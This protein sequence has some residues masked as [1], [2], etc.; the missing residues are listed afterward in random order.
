MP[1]QPESKT[2]RTDAH[3][4]FRGTR[5]ELLCEKHFA[6]QLETELAAEKARA[7]AAEK[8]R[9]AERIERCLK[10]S[11][12]VDEIAAQRDSFRS[13]LES[14]ERELAKANQVVDAAI[15]SDAQLR[16][17]LETL[18]HE[19]DL[20]IRE[21]NRRDAKWMEGIN[22]VCGQK[23]NYDT[24]G[25]QVSPGLDDFLKTLRSERDTALAD[26]AAMQEAIEDAEHAEGCPCA[27]GARPIQDCTCFKVRALQPSPGAE[28][29]KDRERLDWLEKHFE[30]VHKKVSV[31]EFAFWDTATLK[32][33]IEATLRAAI[34]QA[35]TTQE[36]V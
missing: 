25:D 35:R 33:R 28:L 27:Y 19:R 24:I 11:K 12:T 4:S 3:Q 22:E 6:R 23:L 36:K 30:Q 9:D 7:D 2:P 14:K 21:A 13:Q 17:Q 29:L 1:T 15:Q 8:E 5:G 10:W 32:Y 16:Q 26:R 34:D 20:A 31:P 18:T